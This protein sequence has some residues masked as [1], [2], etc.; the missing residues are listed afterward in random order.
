MGCRGSYD[1]ER[2]IR[3]RINNRGRRIRSAVIRS[4][5]ATHEGDEKSLEIIMNE[6]GASVASNAIN[7]PL[8]SSSL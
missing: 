5:K 4:Y 8:V 2:E 7:R 3:K 1:D 6:T